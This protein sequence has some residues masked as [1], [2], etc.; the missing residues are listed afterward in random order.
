M[1]D[2][3]VRIPVE[4]DAG[5]EFGEEL[6]LAGEKDGDI[7]EVAIIGRPN[8]GKSTL[9]NRMVGEERSIVSPMPG[10]TMDNVDTEISR[11]GHHYRFVDTAGNFPQGKTPP[12]AGKNTPGMAPPPPP[13]RGVAPGGPGGG[14]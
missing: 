4:V 6:A 5:L 9:L 13:P 11:E 14:D 1:S 2:L 8:V 7:V 12:V 10:T 3:K